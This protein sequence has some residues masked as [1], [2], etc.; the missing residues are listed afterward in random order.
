MDVTFEKSISFVWCGLYIKEEY[1]KCLACLSVL[2]SAI[3]VFIHFSHGCTYTFFPL[4]LKPR[5][6][7]SVT[8]TLFNRFCARRVMMY[9]RSHRVEV[10][11]H[12]VIRLC[13][14][15]FDFSKLMAYSL[16]LLKASVVKP[17]CKKMSLFRMDA[18]CARCH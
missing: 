7:V 3:L 2:P 15:F 14:I 10:I 9:D 12:Q 13:L 6:K 1:H 4:D 8:S 5:I 17:L 16:A 11:C 18:T